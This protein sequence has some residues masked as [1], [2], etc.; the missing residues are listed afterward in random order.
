MDADSEGEEGTFYIWTTKEIREILG[1]DLAPTFEAYYGVSNG[2]NFEGKNILHISQHFEE[3]S[4]DDDQILAKLEKAR[5]LLLQ[6]RESR[7]HPFRDEKILSGWNG[8]A[9]RS[10]AEAGG[11]LDNANYLKA[12]IKA[13]EFVLSKMRKDDRLLH[14]YKDGQTSGYAFL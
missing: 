10:L 2:G 7:E 11:V 14:C 3:I 8:M 13:L 4:G 6:A 1:D 9:I 5:N 12:G